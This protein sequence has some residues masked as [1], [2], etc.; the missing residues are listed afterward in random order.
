M[1]LG[2]SSL[3]R[4]DATWPKPGGR[5]QSVTIKNADCCGSGVTRAGLGCVWTGSKPAVGATQLSDA[6]VWWAGLSAGRRLPRLHY[7]SAPH[8]GGDVRAS[9]GTLQNLLNPFN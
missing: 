7:G 1:F 9:V 5:C 6:L 3:A 4:S 2:R 8:D